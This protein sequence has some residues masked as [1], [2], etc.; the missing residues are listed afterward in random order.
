VCYYSIHT[1]THTY[2]QQAHSLSRISQSHNYRVIYTHLSIYTTRSAAIYYV[3]TSI[4]SIQSIHLHNLYI[5]TSI[6]LLQ[7][8]TN[9]ILSSKIRFSLSHTLSLSHTTTTHPSSHHHHHHHQSSI[10][11]KSSSPIIP[12]LKRKRKLRSS[13]T[14]MT[15]PRGL[16]DLVRTASQIENIDRPDLTLLH[17]TVPNTPSP[18]T[19]PSPVLTKHEV[20]TL[21][22]NQVSAPLENMFRPHSFVPRTSLDLTS[23]SRVLTKVELQL[24]LRCHQMLQDLSLQGY[25]KE[26]PENLS[27][28]SHLKTLRISRSPSRFPDRLHSLDLSSSAQQFDPKQC[29]TLPVTLKHINLTNCLRITDSTI[30]K[31]LHPCLRLVTLRLDGVSQ[32]TDETLIRLTSHLSCLEHVFLCRLYKITDR[33][34]MSIFSSK[35]AS[36]RLK[37]LHVE[38]CG[39]LTDAS[40]RRLVERDTISG[41]KS[42]SSFTKMQDLNFGGLPHLTGLSAVNIST[43]CVNL[44]SLNLSSSNIDSRGFGALGM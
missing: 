15:R 30:H 42:V 39:N 18:S 22:Q 29:P 38:D 40:V 12:R 17:T 8:T 2:I 13:K 23:W 33:G 20:I 3:N 14:K 32:L 21:I 36:K 35:H 43:S 26:F 24:L 11:M 9:G 41:V 16:E 37:T 10:I 31:F 6:H 25:N 27:S 4:Q 5:Y 34:M 44:T 7:P 19:S 1:H 28:H